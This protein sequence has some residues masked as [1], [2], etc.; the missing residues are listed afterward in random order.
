MGTI[1][2]SFSVV[3]KKWQ[4]AMKGISIVSRQALWTHGKKRG[5]I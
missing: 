2:V 3:V 5:N 1:S 4:K